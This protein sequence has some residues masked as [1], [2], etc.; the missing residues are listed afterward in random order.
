MGILIRITDLLFELN[1]LKIHSISFNQPRTL[2]AEE[3]DIANTVLNKNKIIKVYLE[4]INYIEEIF[5]MKFCPHMTFLKVN[6]INNIDIESCLRNILENIKHESH[7]NLRS[8]CFRVP[9]ADDKI[10]ETLQKMINDNKLLINY[11]IKRLL[12][13]IYLQWK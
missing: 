1:S 5:F 2:S 10:I 9:T 6:C 4:K 8:L 11:T 12:D 3:L 13:N 7:D